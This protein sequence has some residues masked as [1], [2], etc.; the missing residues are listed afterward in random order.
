MS[1]MGEILDEWDNIPENIMHRTVRPRQTLWDTI[2]T[3]VNEVYTSDRRGDNNQIFTRA[4]LIAELE[5]KG[6]RVRVNS[7]STMDQYRNLLSKAKFI[8]T[9]SRG[10]YEVF[11]EVP[12]DLSISDVRNDAYGHIEMRESLIRILPMKKMKHKLHIH[13]I[14][15]A[16]KKEPDFFEKGEFEI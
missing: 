6:Y 8:R 16:K 5:G 3:Y 9:I 1:V 2:K 12:V 4:G 7:Y 15:H 10:V 11:K 13:H 14:H